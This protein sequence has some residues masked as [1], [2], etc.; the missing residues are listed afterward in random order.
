MA[1]PFLNECYVLREASGDLAAIGIS[2]GL[3]L[4]LRHAATLLEVV[5]K[6]ERGEE[7]PRPSS[8]GS[9]P[10]LQPFNG[11]QAPDLR[12]LIAQTRSMLGAGPLDGIPHDVGGNGE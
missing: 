9:A 4:L 6:L 7:P 8:V 1:N 2:H 10:P 11:G 12:A 5:T 3:P